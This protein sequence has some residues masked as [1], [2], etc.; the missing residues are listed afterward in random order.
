MAVSLSGTE[1][2]LLAIGR[3]LMP[4]PRLLMLDKPSPS[5]AHI[6][7]KLVFEIIEGI[8]RQGVIILFVEQNLNSTLETTD[9]AYILETGGI[10]LQG[11][12]RGIS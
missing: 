10:T 6:L 7:V 9:K 11:R 1:Q 3:G 8:N 5:L 12:G 4:F 2:Q